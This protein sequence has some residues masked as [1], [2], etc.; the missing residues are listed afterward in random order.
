[1]VV[2]VSPIPAAPVP[3]AN[4]P[5]CEGQTLNLSSTFTAGATYN[6]AGPNSFTATMQN[7]SITTVSLTSAGVYSVAVNVGGCQG[8]YATV[9]VTVNPIPSAPTATANSPICAGQTLLL[10]STY[11]TAATYTWTGPNSFSSATQNPSVPGTTTLS[12]GDYS[13]AVTVAG[14]TGPVGIISVTV[15]PIPASPVPGSNSPICAGLTLSLTASS[16]GSSYNWSGPNSFTSAVQNP[17]ITSASTLASGD[18]SVTASDLGCT[19]PPAII[20]VSVGPLPAAPTVTVNSPLCSGSTLSLT[21]SFTVGA[22]YTWSGPNSFTSTAQN[23]TIPGATTLAAG[24]YSVYATNNG[25]P[26][27]IGTVSVNVVLPADVNAG[28]PQDTICESAV[29]IPVNGSVTGSTSNGVW[30]TLGSGTFTNPNNLSTT[31]TMSTGDVTGGVITLVL[32]SVG[33]GCPM[34]T[35]TIKYIVLPAP[36]INAGPDLNVCK[37]AMIPLT[38]TITGVTTTGIWTSTG[39]GSFVPGVTSLNGYYA[40]SSSDTSQTS[41]ELVLETTNNKGCLSKTDTVKINFIQ[42]PS[43]AFTYSTACA[44]KPVNFMDASTP[45]ASLASF[46]WDFGDGSGTS[47]AQNPVYVYS[48]GNT[49]TVTHVVT[50]INGCT[51]TSK[52]AVTV[53]ISPV[54]N[55]LFSNVCVGNQSF[56]FDSSTVATG[57]LATWSWNFGDGGT[58]TSANPLHLYSNTGVYTVTMEVTSS[59]GCFTQA[60][61]TVTVN[62][63]PKADFNMNPNPVIAYENVS[64][65]DLSVPAAAPIA[66]WSYLFG[67]AQSSNQQNPGHIYT[68][69]GVY[70]VTLSVID[71]N[72]CSD[73]TRKDIIVAL[74]P[75]VPTAFTPNSDGHNDVLLVKGGPF[76]T[77]SFRVYNNWG[78]LLFTSD[79]QAK[80]WDGT[81]KGQPV[82]LGVYVWIMDVDMFNGEHIRKTG[83]ITVLK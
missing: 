56:F 38:A 59:N 58:S 73:T 43:S 19:S 83:D 82:P 71:G 44:T 47:T 61:K 74:V 20:T 45:T 14:C 27:P 63:R 1:V 26:G 46:S 55:F 42:A 40:P 18:Y 65:T 54:A 3:S 31:Y 75:Q 8:P 6:W 23:P 37:N 22:T 33:G 64:F 53:Y 5:I 21:P 70:T 62:P 69:Q 32:G 12:S 50:S 15:N 78:E 52:Q 80:G 34:V 77:I 17:T 41:I 72:G 66:S 36:T 48:T 68:D 16:T 30:S 39:T 67:D 28:P 2:T 25:C 24:E 81:Y 9:N 57:S 76:K 4:S 13:V 29:F 35:D 7:P 51:D 79:D 11:S 60:V 49:Y 10:S